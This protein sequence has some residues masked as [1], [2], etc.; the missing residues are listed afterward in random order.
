[1]TFL[2]RRY[3]PGTYVCTKN[4]MALSRDTQEENLSFMSAQLLTSHS[5]VTAWPDYPRRYPQGG[6]NPLDNGNVAVTAAD[7][8]HYPFRAFRGNGA[9]V[10]GIESAV[11]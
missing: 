3:D 11:R 5:L 1:M 9:F 10:S 4:N 6:G 7:V 8:R 2:E